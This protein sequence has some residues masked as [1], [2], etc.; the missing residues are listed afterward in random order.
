VVADAHQANASAIVTVP[1]Q[2]YV[3]ADTLG[4]DV[5]QTPNW[6][7]TRFVKSYPSKGQPFADPP[8]TSDQS[9][10]QDEFVWW[11]GQHF[12]AAASDPLRTIFFMLD[13]EPDLWSATHQ[14]VHPNPVTYAEIVSLSVAYAKA[15]KAV[16]PN[17]VVMAPVNYGWQGF[18]DLQ[19]APDANGRDFLEFFLDEMYLAEQANNKRL[20]DVLDVHWYSEAQGNGVRIVGDDTTAAVVEARIQAPRSLWDTTYTEASWITQWSTNGPINLLPR[21]QKKIAD[22]YPG[23]KLSVSEHNHGGGG[24]ISG[25]MALA[26][27]I[28][29]FAR[30]GLFA[31]NMWDM[32]ASSAF[33]YGGFAMFRNYDGQNGSFGDTSVHAAT[34]NQAASSVF[35]SIDAGSPNRVVIVAINKSSSAQ[36]AGIQVT[37]TTALTKARVYQ[38]TTTTPTPVPAADIAITKTNA[39]LYSMPAMSVSTLVIEP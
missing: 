30:E 24:H 23:T 18:V 37:N 11:L 14:E 31:A 9:V 3:A 13:N 28:G 21:L 26:D 8:S 32:G 33:C 20:I 6:M 10:Y 15:I 19:S 39:F 16:N 17:A 4:T 25:G 5:T 2:G 27:V 38:L 29:V 12:P 22:H 7:S 35:A 1:I 36:N 34:S